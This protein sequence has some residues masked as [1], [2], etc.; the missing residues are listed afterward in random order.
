[1]PLTSHR[2]ACLIDFHEKLSEHWA[3][4]AIATVTSSNQPEMIDKILIARLLQLTEG[5]ETRHGTDLVKEVMPMVG[6]H[7][8]LNEK[9]ATANEAQAKFLAEAKETILKISAIVGMPRS[10]NGL[11]FLHSAT[12]ACLLTEM[13]ELNAEDGF[14]SSAAHRKSHSDN[15]KRGLEHWDMTYGKVAMRIINDLNTFYPDLWQFIIKDVY[16]DILSYN[17]ILDASV[18]SLVVICALVPLDVNAQLRGHLRGALNMG[19]DEAFINAVRN[20][21][22]T[23]SVWC[24]IRWKGD[25]VKL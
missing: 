21:S 24:G 11:K 13:G 22:L 18:T 16:S 3:L 4:L 5:N 8:L 6:N 9:F 14:I 7:K 2:L 12:P 17:E 10:I 19:W 25:V 23:L 20:F 15:F 1:M